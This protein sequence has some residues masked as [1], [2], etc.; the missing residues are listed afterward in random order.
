MD[1]EHELLALRREVTEL[2]AKLVGAREDRASRRA[3]LNLMEDAI[4]AHGEAEAAS[5]AKDEF[6]A[7]VSHELR[8]P[9]AAITLWAR[10]LRT[11]FAEA[12]DLERAIASIEQSADSQSRLIDDILDLSRLGSGKLT[13][14][15][16]PTDVRRVIDAAVQAVNPLAAA[17]R[18]TLTKEIDASVGRLVLD[19]GRLT[20]VLWN[21]FTNAIKFTPEGGR[22]RIIARTSDRVLEIDVIDDGEGISAAFIPHVFERFQQA[23]MGSSRRRLGLGIGLTLA[24][25]LVELHGGTIEATSAGLGRGATF[26]VVVPRVDPASD[27]D[28]EKH[29]APQPSLTDLRI[30]LVE[31]DPSTREAM[32]WTLRHAG[33]IVRSVANARDALAAL[34]QAEVLVSDIGLPEVSG[35]ELVARIVESCRE[36][37]VRPLPSCAVSAHTRDTDRRV[38]IDAGF[39]IFLGKPV[40]AEH[41]IEAVADL[42]AML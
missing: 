2:R 32:A 13:L 18:I 8:T 29:A 40:S 36:R 3:A 20:Q 34:D 24:K 33:A 28:A 30:L 7:V 42:R 12:S 10:A 11:G 6:L 19:A 9:L 23:D 39:D 17:K 5:R 25:E 15:R 35:V 31:D 38:A 4:A 1:R 22:V 21:L 27:A 16:E 37:G 14:T 26:H 41:L